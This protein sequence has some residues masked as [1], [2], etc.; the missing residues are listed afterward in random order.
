MNS[1]WHI[2]LCDLTMVWVSVILWFCVGIVFL[3]LREMAR[4]GKSWDY[5]WL[6]ARAFVALCSVISVVLAIGLIFLAWLGIVSELWYTWII[7]FD[8][9]VVCVFWVLP[10]FAAGLVCWAVIQRRR[11]QRN[12]HSIFVAVACP[13]ALLLNVAL[14]FTFGIALG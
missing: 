9:G 11:G 1:Y 8:W 2:N 7:A 10:L 3:R 5:C 6:A 13:S 12:N 14:Y 4:D